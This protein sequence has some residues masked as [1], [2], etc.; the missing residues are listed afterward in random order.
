[1][2]VDTQ[3]F[4]TVNGSNDDFFNKMLNSYRDNRDSVVSFR[5]SKIDDPNAKELYHVYNA[6]VWVPRSD[7]AK[8]TITA[9]YVLNRR[10][11]R[12]KLEEMTG[13]KL[14]EVSP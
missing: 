7:D 10:E 8:I 5:L 3:F 12:T 1:M 6:S 4:K 2:R 13:I 14:K 9:Q 11:A